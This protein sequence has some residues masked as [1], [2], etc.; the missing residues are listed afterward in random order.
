MRTKII[1]IKEMSKAHLDMMC[2]GCENRVMYRDAGEKLKIAGYCEATGEKFDPLFK[3][4]KN[5]PKLK[6]EIVEELP[7]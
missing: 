1:P 3:I 6:Q 2:R 7:F 5:C 4:P